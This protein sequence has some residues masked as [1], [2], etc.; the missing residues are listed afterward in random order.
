MR[1]LRHLILGKNKLEKILINAFKVLESLETLDLHNNQITEIHENAFSHLVGLKEL[2]LEINRFVRIKSHTFKVLHNLR[3]L[4]FR[5]NIIEQ[6]YSN[7]FKK[8]SQLKVWL[9]KFERKLK[10]NI[11]WLP[12]EYFGLNFSIKNSGTWSKKN[13]LIFDTW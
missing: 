7:A 6:I 1:Q 8:L 13:E 11:S 12:T 5:K 9:T 10:T 4:S 2:I 3:Q